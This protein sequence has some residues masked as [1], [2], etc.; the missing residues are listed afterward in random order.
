ML[1]WSA[2]E[3][4]LELVGA[5]LGLRCGLIGISLELCWS[6]VGASLESRWSFVGALLEPCWSLVGEF[7]WSFVGQ[8]PLQIGKTLPRFVFAEHKCCGKNKYMIQSKNYFPKRY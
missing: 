8:A 4:V 3:A 2:S 6:L 1:F 5:S 7:L